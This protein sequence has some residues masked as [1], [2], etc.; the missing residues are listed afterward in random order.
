MTIL[1]LFLN[2]E[3]RTGANRRYLELMESLGEKGN[4]V[5]VIM[6]SF[7]DY[8]PRHFIRIN[9]PVKYK[10][11]SFPR[12]SVLIKNAIIH[13][14][15]EIKLKLGKTSQ[16]GVD[17][18][19]IHGDMHLPA[20]IYLTKKLE[21]RF[22]FAYRCNDIGR[23]KILRAQ[24]PFS[25]SESLFSI[26]FQMLNKRRE[27]QVAWHARLVTFQNSVDQMEFIS[28][29]NYLQENTVLIPGN[30]GLP[31]CSTEWENKNTSQKVEKLV[32][33]GILS[34]S[35]GLG[36]LLEA[37]VILKGMGHNTLHLT[38][39]GRIHENDAVL[40]RV[41]ELGITEMVTFTGYA[42]PFPYLAQADLMVY[43]TLY[44]AFPDTVLEALHTD[45][46]VLASRVGG[47]PDLLE[48]PELLFESNNAADIADRIDRCI[49]ENEFYQHLRKLCQERKEVFK[50]D[51]AQRFETAMKTTIN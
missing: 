39:V 50:F 10:R 13:N 1:G 21:T 49:R 42:L 9:L 46:P 36:V 18:I 11:K 35:K 41:K 3:M 32:Y 26:L 45:C 27:K 43:P 47:M 24:R 33:V 22:F 17:W 25:L 34:I 16:S 6:N 44:D 28:R 7:L 37:L 48:Y 14:I 19:H 12:A 29:T 2:N 51:W 8:S 40:T 30:I 23:E 5:C 31:R 4:T 38:V 15:N 20:A